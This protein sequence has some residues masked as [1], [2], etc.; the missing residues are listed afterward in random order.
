MTIDS[1]L[2]SAGLPD[3]DPDVDGAW[4]LVAHR[5]RRKRAIRRGSVVA[6]LLAVVAVAAG[7]FAVRSDSD[8][9]DVAADS[10]TEGEAAGVW[11]TIPDSPLTPRQ[12]G[13]AVWTGTEMV[14]AGG[15]AADPCGLVSDCLVEQE[16]L[17][18]GAAYDPAA[19]TWRT[20]ADPPIAFTGGTGVWTGDEVLVLATTPL[21][22]VPLPVLLAY[23][24]TSDS[25]STLVS[26]PTDDL[27]EP[28][29]TGERWV[30][31]TRETNSGSGGWSYFPAE[32]RWE[33]LEPDPIGSA[34]ER[35]IVAA[36]GSLFLF[37]SVYDQP[38]APTNGLYR[39]ARFD[40]E[41]RKW[42]TLNIPDVANNGNTWISTGDFVVN[43]TTAAT[44]AEPGREPIPYGAV[45]DVQSGE[46]RP[47]P[48]PPPLA[49]PGKFTRTGYFGDAGGWVVANTRLF[50]PSSDTWV[51]IPP[52]PDGVYPGATVWTGDALITWGG[53]TESGRTRLS[54]AGRIYRPP[55]LPGDSSSDATEPEDVER[56]TT[57]T[58]EAVPISR[59]APCA[60]ITVDPGTFPV[61]SGP[62]GASSLVGQSVAVAHGT[63]SETTVDLHSP[64][65]V[66][67]DLV[68]ERVEDV[69]L[70]RGDAQMWLTDEFVQVRWFTGGQDRCDSF[71]V[72]ASGGTES[73]QREAAVELANRVRLIAE[74]TVEPSE[75]ELVVDEVTL[76]ALP[77]HGACGGPTGDEAGRRSLDI[78]DAEPFDLPADALAAFASGPATYAGDSGLEDWLRSAPR[79]GYVEGRI[80]SIPEMR[81][82]L[83]RGVFDPST[84]PN[85]WAVIIEVHQADDGWRVIRYRASTC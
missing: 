40:L 32:D 53:F 27:G 4:N 5:G 20:I 43:P 66:V 59:E 82:Y 54:A 61:D 19:K 73:S 7:S 11:T 83:F 9:V 15:N 38:D 24:P 71:T 14:I 35:S 6:G 30:F 64:G 34:S 84:A 55:P 31:P 3:H 36:G 37:A 56:T 78:A 46:M 23:D 33:L 50:D 21:T 67:T 68:G 62:S 28:A 1:R 45:L 10:Q 77:A 65:I 16:P 12:P 72:T 49:D 17:G 8:Q 81:F 70:S 80:P 58:S 47:L 44:N 25:W 48:Q 76:D 75:L 74:D 63:D 29:W 2:E 18:D 57:T 39:A 22:A 52:R 69:E 60:S 41:N 26:P 42:V 79:S 51:E 85:T 13:V